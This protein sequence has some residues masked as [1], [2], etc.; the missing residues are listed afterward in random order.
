MKGDVHV[1]PMTREWTEQVISATNHEVTRLVTRIIPPYNVGHF[2][3]HTV[4]KFFSVATTLRKT[5]IAK[6]WH[7][8]YA[9]TSKNP[10][11]SLPSP[12]TPHTHEARGSQLFILG[13]P[14]ML[15][16]FSPV[17]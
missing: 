5:T 4:G 12:V 6:P 3:L 1:L 14:F 9:A 8:A 2:F 10:R 13:A 7:I 15:L 16:W 17:H 11:R